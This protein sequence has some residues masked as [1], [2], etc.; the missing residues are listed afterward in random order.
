M[1]PA[2]RGRNRGLAAGGTARFGPGAAPATL[3][4]FPGGRAG[5]FVGAGSDRAAC[6]NRS[7]SRHAGLGQPRNRRA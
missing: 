6:A 4:L 7:H 3:P 2:A 5:V 1:H